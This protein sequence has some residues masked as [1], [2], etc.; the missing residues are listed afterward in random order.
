[1]RKWLLDGSGAKSYVSKPLLTAVRVSIDPPCAKRIGSSYDPRGNYLWFKG[2]TF[3]N[4][5]VRHPLRRIV[6][7][8]IYVLIR[9]HLQNLCK[10]K[11]I[12]AMLR[13]IGPTTMNSL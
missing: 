9:P 11:S 12:D 13:Y 4:T 7:I 6:L 3:T 10:K 5:A 1:M 2:S 8:L